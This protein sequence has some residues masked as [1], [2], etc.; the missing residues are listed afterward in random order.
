MLVPIR[1]GTNQAASMRTQTYFRLSLD[2]AENKKPT[3]TS[4]SEFCYKLVNLSLEEH[5]NNKI[6]LFPVHEL[7]R[8]QNSPK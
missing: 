1:M 8:W 2:F 4:V 3:E 7:F 6:I 5:K